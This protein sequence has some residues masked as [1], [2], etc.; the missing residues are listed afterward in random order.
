MESS[1]RNLDDW[2]AEAKNEIIFSL[3]ILVHHRKTQRVKNE[4][5]PVYLQVQDI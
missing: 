2:K 3:Q 5:L 4:P 1:Y